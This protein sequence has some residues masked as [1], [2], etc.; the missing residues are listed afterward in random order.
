MV[1][2]EHEVLSTWEAARA[3]RDI[4]DRAAVADGEDSPGPSVG[5][6]EKPTIAGYLERVSLQSEEPK[7]H[8]GEDTGRVVMMTVHVAKG[9]EFDTVFITGMEEELFPYQS[10]AA[11]RED[12]VEEERRLA[13][14]A[15]TRAR[16]VLWVTHAAR[17]STYG[18]TRQTSPSRFISDLPGDSVSL[19]ETTA[20]AS[21]RS[22]AGGSWQDAAA[23]RRTAPQVLEQRVSEPSEVADPRIVKDARVEHATFGIGFVLAVDSLADPTATVQFVS[24]GYG[25][26]VIK[27]RFLRSAAGA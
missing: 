11:G 10:Q 3:V 13:Y 8:G 19:V 12:D 6:P 17:R 23:R 5:P 16:R 21:S 24:G 1:S 22:A 2:Y 25:I 7:K 14:V 9:L 4:D 15:V 20:R 26:R 27:S 18:K